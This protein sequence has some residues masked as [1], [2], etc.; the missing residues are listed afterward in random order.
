MDIENLARFQ[1]AMTTVFHFFFVPFSIG[2]SLMVAILE[3]MFVKTGN[4]E[5]RKQ[6]KFW[7]KIM[8]L[9]FAVGV[10][11][12]IIQEFQFGMNWSDYSRF[13]GD[14]FGAPLAVEALLAFFL[15]STFLGLWMFT[16]DKFSKGIHWL[17][18]CL[19]TAG[20]MTS[21][22]W[23]L[24]ANS[25]MQHPGK[26]GVI[27]EMVDGHPQLKSFGALIANEKVLFEFSHVIAAAVI[28]GGIL[29]A[30]M[31]AW[32]V[33]RKEEVEF[34]KKSMKVG[35]I[36]LTIGA[37][38]N[39]ASGDMQ[40]GAL[41]DTDSQPMKFAA[42]EGDY[43]DVGKPIDSSGS[44]ESYKNSKDHA[45]WTVVGFFNE[46]E[47]KRVWG[48]EIPYMLS[49]LSY[50]APSGAVE[51]M[52]NVNEKLVEQYGEDNYYPAVTALF[53]SFR[54]MAATGMLFLLVGL[55][56]I[57]G[58][59]KKWQFMYEK[60]FFLYVTGLTMFVPFIANSAGW[61][62]TELGR[63]PWTVYGLIKT[64][65]SVSPNVSVASLLVSNII[66]FLLFSVLGI[67]MVYLA[68]KVLKAGPNAG[69]EENKAVDPFD[70]EAINHG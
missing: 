45:S 42:M 37:V 66:Y 61:L 58:T 29:L 10:V 64:K 1:F 69:V 3:G 63:Q 23:I 12:G 11:T 34:F 57:V 56:G 20:S 50:H 16:W 49:V 53:W 9:S 38:F 52:N 41:M 51:G 8:L 28:M 60:K 13:V 59:T 68:S 44:F 55:L 25:F 2:M 5:W 19:V 48:I 54:I 27:Y 7:G 24:I 43:E 30:G 15:E 31:S 67:V 21:A 4:E 6:A 46:K 70:K 17:F 26:V 35:F 39:L 47:H 32:K 18:I 65:D 62:I 22:L 33:I 36:V 40:M 14:I